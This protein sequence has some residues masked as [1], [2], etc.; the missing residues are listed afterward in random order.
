M[1]ASLAFLSKEAFKT[2]AWST[3][4][5]GSAQ[6]GLFLL[7][8]IGGVLDW[9]GRESDPTLPEDLLFGSNGDWLVEKMLEYVISFT[10]LFSDC[11]RNICC[12]IL[13][14]EDLLVEVS[15][16][17][18]ILVPFTLFAATCVAL[19]DEYAFV[20]AFVLVFVDV[21][22]VEANKASLAAL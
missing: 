10:D 11:S 21:W 4:T 1:A 17:V 7:E 13:S 18:G 22:E 5:V 15:G 16:A 3:E 2:A 9:E 6:S 14:L 20:E 12:I 8:T 19:E